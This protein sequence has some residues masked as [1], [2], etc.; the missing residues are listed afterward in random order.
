MQMGVLEGC[1]DGVVLDKVI[2][3]KEGSALG[4]E[5]RPEVSFNDSQIECEEEESELGAALGQGE[6]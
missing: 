6:G 3:S 1:S 2:G 5:L 4:E